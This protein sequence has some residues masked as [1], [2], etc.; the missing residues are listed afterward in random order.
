MPLTARTTSGETVCSLMFDCAA[1]LYRQH[2]RGTL[3]S[4]YPDCDIPVFCRFRVG[5]LAHFVHQTEPVTGYKTSPYSIEHEMGKLI[6]ATHLREAYKEEIHYKV[7]I[8][9]RIVDVV[10]GI[11]SVQV[12]GEVQLSPI[13]TDEI[14][15]RSADIMA[16][17]YDPIWMLSGRA[18]TE[19]NRTWCSKHLCS[20]YSMDF[21]EI[22]TTMGNRAM[23]SLL[24]DF[25]AAITNETRK[26]NHLPN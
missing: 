8:G 19:A 11:G 3:L 14:E 2:P 26:N 20:V 12:A 24:S 15:A 9:D 4:P 23:S 10:C 6:L 7:P 16:M 1:D 21:E 18:N 5:Y 22:K 13:T 17:G 25:R